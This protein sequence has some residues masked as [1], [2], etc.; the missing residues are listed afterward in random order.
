MNAQARGATQRWAGS[1]LAGLTALNP[2]LVNGRRYLVTYTSTNST[3]DGGWREVAITAG[4][5]DVIIRSAGGYT[6]PGRARPSTA[7][8]QQD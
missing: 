8:P 7:A 5:P 1:Q 2:F 3:R 6:A 4:R